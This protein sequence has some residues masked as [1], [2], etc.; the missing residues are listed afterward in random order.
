MRLALLIV[1]SLAFY[2]AMGT[3]LAVAVAPIEFYAEQLGDWL[4]ENIGDFWATLLTGVL[5]V[6]AGISVAVAV[7]GAPF[8][9]LAW[10]AKRRERIP[11]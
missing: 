10:L 2:A 7:I 8:A 11:R 1:A 4:A 6:V 9:L 5:G 3:I